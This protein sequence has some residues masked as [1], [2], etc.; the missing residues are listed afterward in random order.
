EQER[1]HRKRQRAESGIEAEQHD[2][3]ADEQDQV[4]DREDRG[5]EELLQRIDIALQPRHQPADLGPVHERERDHLEV[6][7]H[8][9]AQIEQ[10]VLSRTADDGLHEM[11]GEIIYGHDRDEDADEK[12]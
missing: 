10:Q 12:I 9:A 1:N 6:G 11:V 8:R 3:D 7:V 5:F 2:D 4:A